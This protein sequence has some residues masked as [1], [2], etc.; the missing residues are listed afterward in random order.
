MQWVRNSLMY[1]DYIECKLERRM[2]YQSQ[3]YSLVQAKTD[4]EQD[5]PMK[6]DLMS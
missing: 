5:L 1:S 2:I 4:K 3:D 6:M